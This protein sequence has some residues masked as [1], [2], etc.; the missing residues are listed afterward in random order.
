MII[1]SI[2]LFILSID[3]DSLILVL[4]TSV[5]SL[6][7]VTIFYSRKKLGEKIITAIGLG[8]G[9]ISGTDA[10]LNIYDRVTGGKNNSNNNN[11]GSSSGNS[12][13]GNKSNEGNNSNSE[14]NNN[15]KKTT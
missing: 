8:A 1:N 9:V 6:G 11:G 5:A 7:L 15:G 3:L 14:N 10:G 12:N 2:S 13:E 4:F